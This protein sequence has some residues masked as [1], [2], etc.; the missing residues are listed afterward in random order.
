MKDENECLNNELV[1]ALNEVSL[2]KVFSGEIHMADMLASVS[3]AAIDIA[4]V[5]DSS[6]EEGRKELVALGR[7]INK[8]KD[9]IDDFG[10]GL[11]ADKKKALKVIDDQRKEAR[12]SLDALR[13]EILKPVTDYKEKLAKEIADAAAAEQYL[14]DWEEALRENEFF[15]LR[16][17]AAKN[18]EDARVAKAA[19]ELASKMNRP[20]VVQPGQI[21]NTLTITPERKKEVHRELLE[22]VCQWVNREDATH[23]VF[24]IVQG[25]VKSLKI[26]Y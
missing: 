11:V 10:K 18:A 13:A 14:V 16:R 2:V 9:V 5:V 1:L 23:L 15:N 25:N 4:S 22:E 8:T 3:A 7:K 21:A 17:Q 26:I 12:D 24:N 6:G 19:L 20:F